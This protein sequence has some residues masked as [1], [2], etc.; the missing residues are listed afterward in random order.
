MDGDG[1]AS[2]ESNAGLAA[3]TLSA[4]SSMW[5]LHEAGSSGPVWI[6]LRAGRGS[7]AWLSQAPTVR[8]RA[9]TCALEASVPALLKVAAFG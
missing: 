7:L 6:G 9:G 1:A 5:R 8:E 2:R 4:V 3:G